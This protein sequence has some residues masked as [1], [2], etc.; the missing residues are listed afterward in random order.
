MRKEL[1]FKGAIVGNPW[2]MHQSTL[3]DVLHALQESLATPFQ[4]T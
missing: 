1:H 2:W 4:K 3:L